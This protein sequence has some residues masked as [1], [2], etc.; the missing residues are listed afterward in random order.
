ENLNDYVNE[1]ENETLT[2]SFKNS[3]TE[4]INGIEL[5]V[6]CASDEEI[7]E[8]SE[9]EENSKSRSKTIIIREKPNAS[10]VDVSLSETEKSDSY[11]I[12]ES[13]SKINADFSKGTVENKI[14]RRNRKKSVL[15]KA[16]VSESENSIKSNS[17]DEDYSPITRKRIKKF[18]PKKY[19]KATETKRGRGRPRGR[20]PKIRKILNELLDHKKEHIKESFKLNIDPKFDEK[21]DK[22]LVQVTISNNTDESKNESSGKETFNE[23]YNIK[24]IKTKKSSQ[25]KNKMID[26]LKKLIQTAGIKVHCYQALLK[27]YKTDTSKIKYLYKFLEEHGMVGRPT[28]EKCKKLRIKNYTMKE[29]EELNTKSIISETRSARGNNTRKFI[30]ESEVSASP[31]K[32]CCSSFKRIK[33]IIDSDSE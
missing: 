3:N 22:N 16:I 8:V 6:E 21:A 14:K 31:N 23:Y 29:I 19:I 12:I 32:K 7:S 11:N 15:Y 33:A 13:K 27:D 30:I 2:K 17:D 1:L 20:P 9:R 4:I 10:E 18:S 28:L 5:I 24:N 25:F 26:K